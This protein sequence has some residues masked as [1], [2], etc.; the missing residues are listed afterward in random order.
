MNGSVGSGGS[1]SREAVQKLRSQLRSREDVIYEMQGQMR[2]LELLSNRQLARCGELERAEAQAQK[3]RNAVVRENFETR[4]ELKWSGKKVEGLGK[5]KEE[6]EEENKRLKAGMNKGQ[7]SLEGV[8]NTVSDLQTKNGQLE[9]EVRELRSRYGPLQERQLAALQRNLSA[10]VV[11]QQEAG[12]E[13]TGAGRE[14]REANESREEADERERRAEE[15]ERQAV[16]D[17]ERL[18]REM[19][20]VEEE[21]REARKGLEKVKLEMAAAAREGEAERKEFRGAIAE[22]KRKLDSQSGASRTSGTAPA[23]DDGRAPSRIPKPGPGPGPGP[24]APSTGTRPAS[25]GVKGPLWVPREGSP[26]SSPA[27][28]A[29]ANKLQPL[30]QVGKGSGAEGGVGNGRGT[31][32]SAQPLGYKEGA[33]D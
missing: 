33:K 14:A 12:R 16:E 19:E 26:A 5:E 22:L 9:R 2:E 31:A 11:R 28:G 27:R 10:A 15:R 13:F 21:L 1:T 6:L 17:G 20:G 7:K 23:E 18:R 32:S 24:G 25:P 4:E 8:G 30:K 29:T 3:A